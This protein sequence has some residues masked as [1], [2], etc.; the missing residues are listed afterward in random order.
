[1]DA[2]PAIGDKVMIFGQG[3][4]GLLTTA[5]L[6]DF[7]LSLLVAADPLEYRRTASLSSGADKVI[8]PINP[9]QWT[10]L[11][12]ELFE[13]SDSQGLD[14]C[15]EL[16]GNMDALN[17]AIS[18]TGFAGR[19]IIGSWYGSN[20]KPVQLGTDFHRQRIQLISSQVST[21]NPILSGRWSKRR[22]INLA[23]DLVRR[24]KP[25]RLIT[26]TLSIDQCQKAF[27]LASRRSDNA[28]QVIFE[29]Q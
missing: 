6:S 2:G 10:N 29:F 25:E 18:L 5:L 15:F 14:I 21:V 20:L 4:V 3:I 16:S 22:R 11:K 1:M 17:Q 12:Q 24:I 26:H 9:N 27:E 13:D 8:D 23:W 19:I 7:P 28:L